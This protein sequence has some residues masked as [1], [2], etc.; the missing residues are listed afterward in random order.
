MNEHLRRKG[1][2]GDCV[3]RDLLRS[4]PQNCE[5]NPMQSR[6]GIRVARLEEG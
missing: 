6:S 1:I 5:N 3:S 4:A 2:E